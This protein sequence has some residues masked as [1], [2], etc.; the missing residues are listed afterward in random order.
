[1][2]KQTSVV[3]IGSLRIKIPAQLFIPPDTEPFQFSKVPTF[4]SYF[5]KKTYCGP[6]I[7]PTEVWRPLKGKVANSA[8]PDQMPHQGLHCLQQVQPFFSENI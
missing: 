6:V 3:V 8:D 2:T 7:Y 1:M 5:A 4:F